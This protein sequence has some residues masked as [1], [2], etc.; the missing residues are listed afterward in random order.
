MQVLVKRTTRSLRPSLHDSPS[1]L[2]GLAVDVIPPR[3][4]SLLLL[5][6][7]EPKSDR[8]NLVK[9]CTPTHQSSLATAKHA[10]SPSSITGFL[11][12]FSYVENAASGKTSRPAA[13][14]SAR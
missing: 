4:L 2:L 10:S 12:F 3:P 9:T 8:L 11:K 1:S 5:A 14:S 7:V 13:L 6:A